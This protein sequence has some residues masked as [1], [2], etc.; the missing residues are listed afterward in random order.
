MTARSRVASLVSVLFALALVLSW[1]QF[2]WVIAVTDD[3]RERT[4]SDYILLHRVVGEAIDLEIGRLTA[5]L[6]VGLSARSPDSAVASTLDEWRQSNPLAGAFLSVEVQAASAVTSASLQQ[7]VVQTPT[8]TAIVVVDSV[9]LFE[10]ILPDVVDAAANRM[11]MDVSWRLINRGSTGEVTVL[12]GDPLEGGFD[13]SQAMFTSL[14]GANSLSSGGLTWT[15]FKEGEL[16]EGPGVFLQIRHSRGS[17]DRAATAML[18][19]NLGGG[20]TVVA[21]LLIVATLAILNLRKRALIE[22]ERSALIAGVSHELRTPL[23]AIQAAAENIREGLVLSREELAEYGQLI[24]EQSDRLIYTVEQ[25]LAVARTL[26]QSSPPVIEPVDLEALCASV[27]D[28]LSGGERVQSNCKGVV[29]SNEPA[30]RVILNN[31]ISNGLVHGTTGGAVV[32]DASHHESHLILEVSSEGGQ[33]NARELSRLVQPFER[34]DTQAKGVGLGLTLVDRLSRRL[35]GELRLI[36]TD[37]SRT[38]FQ[39]EIP[40]GA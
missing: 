40:V 15:F 14:T 17:I 8:A 16:S 27:V 21:L 36:D 9:E 20:L 39:V 23:A 25:T 31:L 30:L 10:R 1:L 37:M 2:R 19:R 4:L 12:S 5:G 28:G 35:S 24:E 3:F 33:L 29:R 11:L 32:V 7:L 34:G 13:L 22:Q 26:G 18:V 38:V 6:Q